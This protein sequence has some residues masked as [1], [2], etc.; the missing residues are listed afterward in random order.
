[1]LCAESK[2]DVFSVLHF[3]LDFSSCT[4]NMIACIPKRFA[5]IANISVMDKLE[6]VQQNFLI[7]EIGVRQKIPDN[8]YPHCI[9]TIVC[10]DNLSSDVNCTRS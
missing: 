10:G 7:I 8:F 2:L 6:M 9:C 3:L 5:L 1:M 4:S